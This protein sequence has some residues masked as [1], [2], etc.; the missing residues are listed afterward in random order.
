MNMNS[1]DWENTEMLVK[2]LEASRK[3]SELHTRPMRQLIES[4][5]S[6]MWSTGSTTGANEPENVGFMYVSAVSGDLVQ[7]APKFDVTTNRPEPDIQLTSA[8]LAGF[9]NTWAKES[10]FI[11]E[12]RFCAV[13]ILMSHTCVMIQQTS[14]DYKDS[15]KRIP[16]DIRRNLVGK[17]KSA[18]YNA[19]DSK[20]S[21]LGMNGDQSPL[22]EF[23][24]MLPK[25]TRLE[26]GRWGFDPAAR[27]FEDSRY[28]WHEWT[29]DRDILIKHAEAHPEEGWYVERIRA[30]Q[31]GS[32]A[33]S[34]GYAAQN[35]PTR[36]DVIISEMWIP[37]Y[38]CKEDK[39][40]EDGYHGSI[41]TLGITVGVNSKQVS[42]DVIREARPYYGHPRGPFVLGG[43]Y[44]VPGSAWPLGPIAANQSLIED[45][46]AL[47]RANTKSAMNYKKVAGVPAENAKSMQRLAKALHDAVIPLPGMDNGR[48]YP[49]ELGGITPQMLQHEQYMRDRLER[50]LGFSA[51]ASGQ[52]S[53]GISATAD[54]L[55]DQ[56]KS[57]RLV[58]VFG[59]WDAFVSDI[60]ERVIWFPFHSEDVIYPL[61]RDESIRLG[62]EDEIIWI[63]GGNEGKDKGFDFRDIDVRVL[64][65]SMKNVD[66]SESRALHSQLVTL[67]MQMVPAIQQFPDVDWA[68][69]LDDLG[70]EYGVKDWSIRWRPEVIA[71][72]PPDE[73]H[74]GQARFLGDISNPDIQQQTAG[75]NSININGG[76][77]QARAPQSAPQQQTNP[78][79]GA[80]PGIQFQGQ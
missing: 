32:D 25:V 69:V 5:H 65:G 53:A 72:Y 37:E 38:R 34:L 68:K 52:S 64:V 1:M 10:R 40:P 9:A 14:N 56:A 19:D 39:K 42:G 8:S 67:T 12:L 73:A 74:E 57:K 4:Y 15:P 23:R 49:I 31:S 46:N 78:S 43:I 17:H 44:P 76:G 75:P 36:N 27:K 30:L 22:D 7:F 3:N 41:V 55:A 59:R 6:N 62:A 21:D 54:A 2:E 13:E 24:P 16:D 29:R 71:G 61:S 70:R 79:S 80:Q 48:I 50:N 66:T 35:I 11:E 45:L 60:I 47:A 18:A 63:Q 77:G 20:G 33:Y 28:Y 58:P 51:V 26:P